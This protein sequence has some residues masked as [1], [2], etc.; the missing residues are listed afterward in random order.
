METRPIQSGNSRGRTGQR[1][2]SDGHDALHDSG[3]KAL[4][5]GRERRDV[6]ASQGF[7]IRSSRFSELRTSDRT[8]LAYP[9]TLA[10]LAHPARRADRV[11]WFDAPSGIL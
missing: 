3:G 2:E 5:D 11:A 9:A 4:G 1:N 6:H 7:E 8:L 10:I